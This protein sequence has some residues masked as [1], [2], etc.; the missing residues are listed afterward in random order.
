MGRPSQDAV[1]Y[2]HFFPR[3]V[4]FPL[5]FLYGQDDHGDVV[6]LGCSPGKGLDILEHAVE[7]LIAR[8][9]PCFLQHLVHPALAVLGVRRVMGLGDAVGVE[10]VVI[11]YLR[12]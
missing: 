9:P 1:L 10:D 3:S 11:L 4:L 6:K 8:G 7:H 5:P 2:Q 12:Y